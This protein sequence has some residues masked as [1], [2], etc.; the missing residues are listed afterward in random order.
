MI[1]SA[2]AL[3][4]RVILSQG[5]AGL[6]RID[7]G[8]DCLA[9]GEVNQQALFR[10]IGAV[11]HHG[12]AGTTTVAAAAG[13][14][15]VIIPQMYDQHYWAQ[16]VDALGVGVAHAA[17]AMSVASM[18]AALERALHRD[19]ATRAEALAADVRHDGAEMAAM[20]LLRLVV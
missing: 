9:I 19:V 12:G 14:P 5:W 11:V 4:R 2:R 6:T 8:V 16:R 3:G 13:V 15:Q 1:E 18:T 7:D 10:R 17:G 20:R